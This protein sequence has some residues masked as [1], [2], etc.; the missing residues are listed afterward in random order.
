MNVIIANAQQQ[1]L[2]TLD[3]D[4]IKNIIGSYESKDIAQIFKNFF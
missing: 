2:S 1:A 3:I 4:I